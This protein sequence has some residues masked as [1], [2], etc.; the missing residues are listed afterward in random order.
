MRVIVMAR[1]VD[2]D[3]MYFNCMNY[4]NE[5]INHTFK[6]MMNIYRSNRRHDYNVNLIEHEYGQNVS[7]VGSINTMLEIDIN[8]KD[9]NNL[10]F[11]L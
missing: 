11:C 9:Q 6:C 10:V 8:A 3:L 2:V 1:N 4:R 7:T 5:K